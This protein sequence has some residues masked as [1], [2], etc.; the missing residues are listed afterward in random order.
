M[1]RL[2]WVCL[3]GAAG[4]GARYLVSSC[5]LARWSGGGIP[6]G[7]LCVNVMGSFL[8]G[9]ILRLASTTNW[10]SPTTQLALTVGVLG[11][12][13]TY[14][15]FA[16]ETFARIE[17]GAWVLTGAYVLG[18]VAACLAAVFLGNAAARAWVGS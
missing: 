6:W 16:Y 18:T 5:A 4:S 1:E 11:G 14:S 10:L 13:T 9:L 12:F 8:I 3:G 15:A 7:T 2:A 17:Q